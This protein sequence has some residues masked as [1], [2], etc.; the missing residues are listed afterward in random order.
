MPWRYSGKWSQ[1]QGRVSA[2][3]VQNNNTSTQIL[4]LM[5]NVRSRKHRM[6][7][8]RSSRQLR[9]LLLHLSWFIQSYTGLLRQVV[10][11]CMN[12]TKNTILGVARLR[13]KLESLREF[14]SAEPLLFVP[15]AR[16]A[17]ATCLVMAT[18]PMTCHEIR[19]TWKPQMGTGRCDERIDAVETSK[20][21]CCCWQLKDGTHFVII[22]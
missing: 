8:P 16:I 10:L 17:H 11:P 6:S 14:W 13:K 20:K 9:T 3:D 22:N 21:R 18:P 7:H 1:G 4:W 12:S 19:L 15:Q 5:Q 2:G